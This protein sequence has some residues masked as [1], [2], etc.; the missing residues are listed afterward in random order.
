MALFD[1][2]WK[3]RD[4]LE[5]LR[6]PDGFVCPHCQGLTDWR[7]ADGYLACADCVRK[8]SVTAGT[9]LGTRT[10]LTLWLAAAWLITT[11]KNGISASALH[12]EFDLGSYQTAWVMLHRLRSVMVVPG[13]DLLA[14][15]VEV[16]ETILGGPEPGVRRRG[17]LGKVLI[18]VA[19]EVL[20]VTDGWR[21]YPAATKGRYNHEALDI[22]ASDAQ[23][24]VH[25][26]V[27][28]LKRWI[29]GT[30]DSSLASEHL[31]A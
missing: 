8:V 1:E 24:A 6:W 14:G 9:V 19:V 23:A 18:A 7:L 30:L 15:R 20:S 17:A 21:A 12:R 31:L 16:D 5:W 27:S 10:P 22:F 4:Y 25:S 11:S 28:R 26:V 2:D 29:L 13:R 3:C